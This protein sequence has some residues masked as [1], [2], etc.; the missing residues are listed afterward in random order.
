MADPV[1]QVVTEAM[2]VVPT[3]ETMVNR[4]VLIQ[5]LVKLSIHYLERMNN[6]PNWDE[7][8]Q[9]QLIRTIFETYRT[10]PVYGISTNP[11]KPAHYVPLF[12]SQRFT[13]LFP[14]T[15]ML[16]GSSDGGVTLVS[17]KSGAGLTFLRS[18]DHLSR[19]LL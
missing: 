3:L 13:T 18:F 16:I 9:D 17:G 12:S 6:H 15:Q 19:C 5:A 10:I 8:E 4:Q 1:R 7:M 2:V 11:N 14:L